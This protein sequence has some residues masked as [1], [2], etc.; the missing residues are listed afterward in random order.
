V[1]D[2]R[3]LDLQRDWEDL[4]SLDPFWAILSDDD[5]RAAGWDLQEFL[6]T[7]DRE[8]EELLRRA[9]SF[10]LPERHDRALDFGCG[11]GRLT[12]PM[13][14]AFGETVGVDIS[15]TMIDHARRI[16]AGLKNC[17]FIHSVQPDLEMLDDASFDLVYSNLVLQHLPDRD[18]AERY[19]QELV[20][21]LRPGGLLAFQIPHRIPLR[22]RLQPRRR[23]YHVLRAIGLGAVPLYRRGGLHP[24]RMIDLPE[25]RAVGIVTAAGGR[26]LEIDARTITDGIEDR[27]YYVGRRLS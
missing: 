4:G 18:A 14:G 8:I 24:V 13:S 21:V 12:R 25:E 1:G 23:L 5:R 9:A 17:S 20:R 22:H 7:G 11:V 6:A 19:V 15:A 2:S 27:T 10:G 3:L 16:S 26:A